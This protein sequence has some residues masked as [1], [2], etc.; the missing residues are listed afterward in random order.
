MT[1]IP[2]S[3]PPLSPTDSEAPPPESGATPAE[4]VRAGMARIHLLGVF[5]M[6]SS[7]GVDV[8]P[9]GHKTRALLAYLVLAHGGIAERSDLTA[10]LWSDR[11][12][13][14]GRDSLRQCLLDARR[15]FGDHV[16]GLVWG[17]RRC[18]GL[19]LARCS[20]DLF[21]LELNSLAGSGDI[22]A[23]LEGCDPRFDQWLAREREA[24]RVHVRSV[25]HQRLHDA[26][27]ESSRTLVLRLAAIIL[28]FDPIDDIA[29]RALTAA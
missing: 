28:R 1:A 23:G 4:S 2:R 24:R 19:D 7:T 27:Q 21:D 12:R 25:L 15:S 5:R 16:D 20:V 26:T 18:V 29:K 8:T 22:L 3:T 11:P 13:G 10:L 6:A 17:D 14:H 9:R